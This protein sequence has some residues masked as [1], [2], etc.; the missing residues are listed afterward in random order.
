MHIALYNNIFF[1][2]KETVQVKFLI[3]VI[4]KY[5]SDK[6]G[7]EKIYAMKNKEYLKNLNKK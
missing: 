4:V 6:K 1:L 2:E 5:F 3:L 7:S